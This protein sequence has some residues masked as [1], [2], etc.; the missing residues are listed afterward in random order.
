MG[1]LQI[2]PYTPSNSIL[3]RW[4]W[5]I[6]KVG[7]CLRRSCLWSILQRSRGSGQHKVAPSTDNPS[8]T[9]LQQDI[10][11]QRIMYVDDESLIGN[12]VQGEIGCSLLAEPVAMRFAR[13]NILKIWKGIDLHIDLHF[14]YPKDKKSDPMFF[15]IC[16]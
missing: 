11:P 16:K 10:V 6:P 9:F 13:E 3:L 12:L 2:R 8:I 4:L 15:E 14:G 5:S 7:M 1:M